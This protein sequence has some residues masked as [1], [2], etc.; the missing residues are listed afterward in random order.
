MAD[1]KGLLFLTGATGHTG[2]RVAGRLLADGWRLRC[3]VRTPGHVRHLP[4]DRRLEVIAGDIGDSSGWAGRLGG[5]DAVIHMAHIGFAGTVAAACQ[6]AGVR[7]VIAL[8]ST[9][10]FTRYPD[11]TAERVIRGEAAFEQSGLDYTILRP[12][13][14]FGGDRDNNLERVA[15][16]LRR[17]RFLP[18]V[19]GGRQLVQPI[20]VG[21]LVEAVV[22]ALDR[23]DTT[24]RRALTVAGPEPMTWRSMMEALGR[25]M[26][27]PVIWVPVPYVLAFSAAAILER[28]M[29]RPPATRATVRRLL[30]DKAFDIGEASEALGG[31]TPRPFD[32]A[33]AL[34]RAGRA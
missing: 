17:W 14:I 2:S 11:P 27:R 28:V 8:S 4:V 22:R 30:E 6:T 3:L 26:D 25:A 20:F 10:R 29:K 5:C 7:R 24:R 31:W 33:L 15:A 34:K 23:T 21:D 32:E 12:T 9:R 18:C 16:W 19:A 13:M 1:D